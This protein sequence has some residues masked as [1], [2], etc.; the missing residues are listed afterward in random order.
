MDFLSWI[1]TIHRAAGEGEAISLLLALSVW[2]VS[3]YVFSTA[4]S[5]FTRRFR[6]VLV[7]SILTITP[8]ISESLLVNTH[9]AM[10]IFQKCLGTFSLKPSTIAVILFF[11]DSIFN[12][13]VCCISRKFMSP[14]I[15]K[16][17]ALL[18]IYMH[19]LINYTVCSSSKWLQKKQ[20]IAKKG[21]D[22]R[23]SPR[24]PR[25]PLNP[26][27]ILQVQITC[28][29][30]KFVKTLNKIFWWISW[31]VSELWYTATDRSFE[32]YK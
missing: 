9:V 16:V 26:P 17:G 15:Q 1:F 25:H 8:F 14:P 6:I 31:F 7:F 24:P 30:K 32:N 3:W 22:V 28:M 10:E 11:R 20:V 12:F 4:K 2:L 5:L 19:L 13:D 23:P 21:G 27:L 29:Q 18:M